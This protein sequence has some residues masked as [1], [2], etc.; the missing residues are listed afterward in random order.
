MHEQLPGSSHVKRLS[1]GHCER[2]VVSIHSF[3]PIL[4]ETTDK[5][6]VVPSS[7]STDYSF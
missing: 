1:E 5:L 4:F 2:K 6:P 7:D 3:G